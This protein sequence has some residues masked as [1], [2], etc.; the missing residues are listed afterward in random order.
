M[1]PRSRPIS[2]SHSPPPDDPQRAAA[3]QVL[4]ADDGDL[5]SANVALSAPGAAELDSM[6]ALGIRF[7]GSA[8]RFAGYRYS[9]LADALNDARRVHANGP[10]SEVWH[11]VF[12]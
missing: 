12:K 4:L 3:V 9:D 5:P 11:W 8:Y 2:S 7:D 10:S 1:H 6:E